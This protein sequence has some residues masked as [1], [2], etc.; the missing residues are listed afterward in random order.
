MQAK[1]TLRLEKQLVELY[2]PSSHKKALRPLHGPWARRFWLPIP[3]LR[4]GKTT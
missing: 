1:L 4:T 2:S 3:F